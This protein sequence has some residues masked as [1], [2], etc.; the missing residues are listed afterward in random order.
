MALDAPLNER[1]IEVLR[2]INDGCPDGRWTDFTFKTTATALASRRLVTVSKRGGAWSAAILPPGEYYIANNDYPQGHW[3]KRRSYQVNLDAPVRPP[4]VA[5]RPVVTTPATAVP[6]APK[7][8]D[9][10]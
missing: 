10:S 3:A 2:W 5:Q 4:V 8:L 6:S 7:K 9:S 1:Q